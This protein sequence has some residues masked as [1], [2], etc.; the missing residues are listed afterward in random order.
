MSKIIENLRNSTKSKLLYLVGMEYL[1]TVFIKVV[2]IEKKT[3]HFFL[4][5]EKRKFIIV[6]QN[7]KNLLKN[8]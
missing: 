5:L 6:N 4:S 7:S 3:W 8:F 1:Q 2:L